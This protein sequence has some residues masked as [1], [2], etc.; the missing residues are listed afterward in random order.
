MA[1]NPK[2]LTGAG[3]AGASASAR[4]AANAPAGAP[5]LAAG[6]RLY[7]QVCVAC[8]GPEGNLVPDHKLSVAVARQSR[9]TTSA[10]IKSPK[11]PMPKM[12]P[13]L[14]NEQSIVDVTDYLYQQWG[15]HD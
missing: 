9:A 1:L 12:Y 4:V 8:H 5:D 14:L 13:D 3:A 7:S 10:Y 15:H 6:R 11:P 2:T